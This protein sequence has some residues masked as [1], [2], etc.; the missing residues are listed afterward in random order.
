MPDKPI[1]TYTAQASGACSESRRWCRLGCRHMRSGLRDHQRQ[2]GDEHV[3]TDRY[4][5]GDGHVVHPQQVE[6]REQAADARRRR[7][8]RRRRSRATTHLR[9]STRPSAPS[10]AG[11]RPSA[12][13]AAADRCSPRCHGAGC[14]SRRCRPMRCRS[15]R[16]AACRTAGGCRPAQCR[17]PGTRRRE[18]D[19]AAGRS[20]A[21]RKRLPRHI[22]PMNVPSSTPSDTAEDPITSCRS[23]NQTIS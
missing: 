22:P 23:W 6:A 21:A 7:C 4:E 9:A 1:A 16:A 14:R 18:A 15:R 17:V 3:Q 2:A 19:G 5:R 11:S 8:C 20:R 12:A 13:S 10:P